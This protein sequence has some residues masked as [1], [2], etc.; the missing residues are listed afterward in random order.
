MYPSTRPFYLF[1]RHISLFISCLCLGYSCS[2]KGDASNTSIQKSDKDSI[3]VWVDNSLNTKNPSVERRIL[4]K[5]ALEVANR[6][7]VDSSK[8]KYFSK[9]QWAY[10]VLDD[11]LEFRKTNKIARSVARSVGDSSN[12]AR[13]YWDL[14]YF[15]EK[16]D[17]NDSAYYYYAQSQKIFNNLNDQLNAGR[18][19]YF[20]A[21]IQQEV[22]DYTGS[23]TNTIKAIELLKPL[24]ANED[25]FKC[26]SLLGIIA[27][28]LREYDRSLGY[29]EI[30]NSH[31]QK[32][33]NKNALEESEYNNIGVVYQ[34][35]G[36][37]EKANTYFLKALANE[38]LKSENPALYARV[39]TNLALSQHMIDNN[40]NVKDLLSEG[41]M[42]RDSIADY[43]GL[44]AS[45]YYLAE[46]DLGRRDSLGAMAN[47]NKAQKY[48]KQS[49]N[50]ER[51]LE[52]LQLLTR[53][54][55]KNATTYTRQYIRLSDSLQLAERQLRD[56]FARIRFE[57]D[58]FIA[59][60]EVLAEEKEVL[61]TQKK[62]WA[63]IALGVLVLSILGYI[64]FDQRRKNQKLRFQRAQQAAN[65]EIFNLMLSQ[66]Q[67]VEEGKK[68]EQKR[69]S[70]EL[71]DGVLGKMLGARMVLTGLNKKADDKALTLKQ[72]A[73]DLLQKIEGEIRSISHALSNSA[74]HEIP[75]FIGS[76]QSLLETTENASKINTSLTHDE[77]V[78][79]DSLSGDIKINLYRIIQESVQ[80]AVKHAQCK[81]IVLNFASTDNQL[82]ISITD[83]GKGFEV[84][85]RKKGIGMRNIGSRIEKLGGSWWISSER[86]K[87]TSLQLKIPI[88]Y[89]SE[90]LN[91]LLKKEGIESSSL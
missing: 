18:F 69:I 34:E 26:Y 56:K 78:D 58:E 50:N 60:N 21:S 29:Y 19:L 20:M 68:M 83:D 14:A 17:I 74:Y 32:L 85:K 87:G 89:H 10:L 38:S 70:E 66:H 46:Y 59:E 4:L 84:K 48:A 53:I 81:H 57:T 61:T 36:E 62:I 41:L 63:G 42:I 37:Y 6:S 28:D 51:L 79:W 5:K 43:T 54:D 33:K 30:A 88:L 8:L 47:A 45:Y 15:F 71:H 12:L 23:E 35:I 31:L 76:I 22:K 7:K 49:D 65:Q 13:R 77:K 24:N 25:L 44:S 27:K 52:T 91:K 64:M 82:H 86:G 9:I 67:K 1:L 90:E 16:K 72:E 80:N 11:S 73:L 75:N 2:N 40:A 3:L 55:P 39:L